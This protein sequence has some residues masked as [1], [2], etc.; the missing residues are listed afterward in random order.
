MSESEKKKATGDKYTRS[1]VEIVDDKTNKNTANIEAQKKAERVDK[2]D[3]LRT[4]LKTAKG[5]V[6]K[7]LNKIELAVLLF[8]K[9]K[10]ERSTTKRTNAKPKEIQSLLAKLKNEYEELYYVN[11]D[12]KIV[13]CISA[14]DELEHSRGITIE[15]LETD[16]ETF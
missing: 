7:S 4:K 15:N 3:Q 5:K 8:E 9:Y 10:N 13:I 6:T 2:M 14:K 12:L 16:V 1:N 11:S